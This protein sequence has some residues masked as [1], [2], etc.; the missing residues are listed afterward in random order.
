M[1]SLSIRGFMTK[2]GIASL[3]VLPAA[4]FRPSM[5]FATML[6][7]PHAFAE[8]WAAAWNAH[9]LERIL[10]HYAPDVVFLSP[11]AQARLGAGRLVGLDALRTYWGK[12]LAAY[13][14]LKFTAL[15]VY[16]GH[17]SLAI[18]YENQLGRDVIETFEFG[19]D[20]KVIR[21]CACY[22]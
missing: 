4:A 3:I 14:D 12:G 10:G 21:S 20:G 1:D 13:P 8:E 7:D 16:G 19:V 9:D 11:V 2:S 6:P 22:A 17:E 15:G 18:R 5:E